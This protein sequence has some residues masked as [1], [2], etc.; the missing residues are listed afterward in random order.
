M[1]SVRGRLLAVA[2]VIAAAALAAPGCGN[3]E[4]GERCLLEAYADECGDGLTCLV[5]ASCVAAVCCPTDGSS[6]DPAC[7]A[8]P[9][10]DGS[11]GASVSDSGGAGAGGSGAGGQGGA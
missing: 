10:L 9:A 4:E 5:P 11:G 8:C 3:T 1:E 6:T 2:V 7:A